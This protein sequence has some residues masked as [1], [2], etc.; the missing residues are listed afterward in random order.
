M[1]GGRVGAVVWEGALSLQRGDVY[2][3]PTPLTLYAR[4]G[5]H[6]AV[7]LPH[8][9]D[10]YHSLELLGRGL[11]ERGIEPHSSEMHPGIESPV[12]LDRSVGH[13]LYPSELRNVGRYGYCLAT[14][15]PY[16]FYQRVQPLLATSRDDHFCSPIGELEGRISSYATRRPHHDDDLFFNRLELHHFS[17]YVLIPQPYTRT[18]NASAEKEII[19]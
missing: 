1:L 15:V 18:T 5:C 9:V 2:E 11:F 8:E 19:L 6:R 12:L 3:C 17:L 16:L 13:L 7:D 14:I 10:V 4:Q